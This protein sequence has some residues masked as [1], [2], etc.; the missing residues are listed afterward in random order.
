MLQ[1]GKD[2]SYR[3]SKKAWNPAFWGDVLESTLGLGLRGS[4]R[5]VRLHPWPPKALRYFEEENMW[6]ITPL[7][8]SCRNT[9]QHWELLIFPGPVSSTLT[10]VLKIMKTLVLHSLCKE[11]TEGASKLSGKWSSVGQEGFCCWPSSPDKQVQSLDHFLNF[12]LK[13]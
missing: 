2:R 8:E 12:S 7:C 6:I 5:C 1:K 10:D 11:L 3:S 13:I 4:Q 9:F